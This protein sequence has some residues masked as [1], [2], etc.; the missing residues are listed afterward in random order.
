MALFLEINEEQLAMFLKGSVF[1]RDE[2]KSLKYFAQWPISKSGDDEKR[3]R[4]VET[5]LDVDTDQTRDFQRRNKCSKKKPTHAAQST[6]TLEQCNSQSGRSQT[7]RI[8]NDAVSS[9]HSVVNAD[10]TAKSHMVDVKEHAC[11]GPSKN[12]NGEPKL[13]TSTPPGA[14]ITWS[15]TDIETD[16]LEELFFEASS[17]P[18]EQ[19]LLRSIPNNRTNRRNTKSK[20]TSGRT[21][22]V[23]TTAKFEGFAVERIETDENTLIISAAN[24]LPIAEKVRNSTTL[25]AESK[26]S[27]KSLAASVSTGFT[28]VDHIEPHAVLKVSGDISMPIVNK[29]MQWADTAADSGLRTHPI[30]DMSPLPDYGEAIAFSTL[31]LHHPAKSDCDM[32]WTATSATLPNVGPNLSLESH[33]Q[34]EVTLSSTKQIHPIRSPTEVVSGTSEVPSEIVRPFDEEARG[35]KHRQQTHNTLERIRR[36][37]LKKS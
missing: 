28:K 14:A 12:F 4:P 29:V 3:T 1:T 24:I 19:P 13:S 36:R 11:G 27:P 15:V 25:S 22:K 20:R 9:S 18:F 2:M 31:P 34:S 17:R 10:A 7:L 37:E 35:A 5:L 8:Y 26:P 23:H 6:D 21:P 30:Y 33:L 32:A 16:V